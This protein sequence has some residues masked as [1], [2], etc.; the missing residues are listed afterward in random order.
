MSVP[1]NFAKKNGSR[2][3]SGMTSEVRYAASAGSTVSLS[4]IA[5]RIERIVSNDGTGRL[6]EP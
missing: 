2:V 3:K 6:D 1:L 5:L 4:P